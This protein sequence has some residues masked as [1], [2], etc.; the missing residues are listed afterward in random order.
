[1]L[2]SAHPKKRPHTTPAPSLWAHDNH[3]QYSTRGNNSVAT[4]RGTWWETVNTCSGT[5]TRVK[6]GLVSVRNLRRHRTV[7]VRAGHSYLARK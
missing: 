7:L 3:G 5:L 1:M 4:V 6:K 2:A